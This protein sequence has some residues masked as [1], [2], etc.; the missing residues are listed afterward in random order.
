MNI[1]EMERDELI[2]SEYVIVSMKEYMLSMCI[3]SFRNFAIITDLNLYHFWEFEYCY[4]QSH[5]EFY[6]AK[7]VTE[8]HSNGT[9]RVTERSELY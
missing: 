6:N 4:N 3:N 1:T 9:A 7:L 5:S 8:K 2:C